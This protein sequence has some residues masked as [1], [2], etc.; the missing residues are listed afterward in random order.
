MLSSG[1]IVPALQVD[2]RK[3]SG[4]KSAQQNAIKFP[5]QARVLHPWARERNISLLS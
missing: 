3:F 2:K 5:Q 4:W 1:T